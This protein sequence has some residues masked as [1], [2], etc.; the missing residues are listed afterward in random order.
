MSDVTCPMALALRA[1]QRYDEL[2]P[3]GPHRYHLIEA[4]SIL[5]YELGLECTGEPDGWNADGTV[6]LYSHDGGTC[7]I[8]EW[9]V[10]NDQI[11][12]VREAS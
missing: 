6:A 8:H 10:P 7:P 9:L 1:L 12:L 4:E 11:E 2:L 3:A 5:G